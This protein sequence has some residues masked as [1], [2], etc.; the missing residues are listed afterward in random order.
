[1][2]SLLI[3][4]S[5]GTRVVCKELEN[6]KLENSTVEFA[7]RFLEHLK[8]AKPPAFDRIR[9]ALVDHKQFTRI[10]LNETELKEV[11]RMKSSSDI[12]VV[13]NLPK[14]N[15]TLYNVP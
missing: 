1:M 10:K 6:V 9:N 11:I 7:T 13:P 3:C 14:S 15:L 4:C 12:K 2:Y 8:Q 5:Q